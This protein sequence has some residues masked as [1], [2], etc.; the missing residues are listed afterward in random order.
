MNLINIAMANG[1]RHVGDWICQGV[2][3]DFGNWTS[4]YDLP[5]GAYPERYIY[6]HQ[7]DFDL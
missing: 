1:S 6:F 3:D 7:I 4:I 2:T 5:R